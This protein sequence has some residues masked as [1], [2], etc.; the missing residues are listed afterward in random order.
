MGLPPVFG[1][2]VTLGMPFFGFFSIAFVFPLIAYGLAFA[3]SGDSAQAVD[4]FWQIMD[5]SFWIG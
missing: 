4:A 2:Q 1:W 3:H 5:R